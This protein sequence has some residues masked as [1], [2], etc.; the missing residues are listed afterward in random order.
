MNREQ[1]VRYLKEGIN[2]SQK[3]TEGVENG[4]DG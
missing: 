1:T 4:S 2:E 3:H